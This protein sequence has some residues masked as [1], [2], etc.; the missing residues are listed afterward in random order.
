MRAGNGNGNVICL[1]DHARASST[2]RAAKRE[3]QSNVRPAALALR[4]DKTDGHQGEGMLSRLNHLITAQFVAPTSAAISS[5]ES[6]REMMDRNDAGL[7]RESVMPEVLGQYVPICKAIMV[8]DLNS[9]VGH[10]VP[11]SGKPAKNDIAESAWLKAWQER[12]RRIQGKRT[13]EA[14]AL[15]LGMGVETWKKCV[16]RGDAFPIRKLPKLAAFAGIEVESLINGDKDHELP[17][18]VERYKRK[19][20][21]AKRRAV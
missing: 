2:S 12:L 20:A 8:R 17:V 21:V 3:S 7:R 16:N 4:V 9:A 15:V 18:P 19:A 6:Q 1:R 11:M 5:R 14:M 10:S 13:H